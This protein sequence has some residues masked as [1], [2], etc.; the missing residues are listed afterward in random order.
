MPEIKRTAKSN[1][2]G[3]TYR[4]TNRSLGE[5]SPLTLTEPGIEQFSVSEI[6]LITII[7]IGY[8]IAPGRP[9]F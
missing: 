7:E 6:A 4:Q 1:S 9:G 2:I 5:K 3:K 8:L